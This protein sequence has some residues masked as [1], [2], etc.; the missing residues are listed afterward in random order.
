MRAYDS[1]L[2][3]FLLSYFGD[4]ENNGHNR[5]LCKR[6]S[7]HRLDV[8]FND[9]SLGTSYQS[10]EK[11]MAMSRGRDF[12]NFP[13]D[14]H[15]W[16]LTSQMQFNSMAN[17]EDFRRLFSITTSK[18]EVYQLQQ[19]RWTHFYIWSSRQKLWCHR[20]LD[21]WVSSLHFTGYDR[22]CVHSS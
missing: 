13:Y 22:V 17:F 19:S 12:Y 15:I 16:S 7:I 6:L 10:F 4:L 9:I 2:Y 8:P 3:Q 21:D 1:T 11:M 18:V 5:L 14:S 20:D